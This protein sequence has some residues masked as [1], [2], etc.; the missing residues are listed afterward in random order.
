MSEELLE[1]EAE[2]AY[3]AEEGAAVPH[4]CNSDAFEDWRRLFVAEA[5]SAGINRDS[6]NDTRLMLV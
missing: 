5:I 1:L 6:F 3:L 2:V 4:E